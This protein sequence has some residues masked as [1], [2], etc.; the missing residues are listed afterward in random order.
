M[1]PSFGRCPSRLGGSNRGPRELMEEAA[2]PRRPRTRLLPHKAQ[3]R[4]EQGSK[5]SSSFFVLSPPF[6]QPPPAPTATPI[7]RFSRI[8]ARRMAGWLGLVDAQPNR[9]L[10]ALACF[11]LL[12]DDDEEEEDTHTHAFTPSF[13][14]FF[15]K[16]HSTK[17]RPMSK[18]EQDPVV[19][20]PEEDES[21]ESGSDSGSDVRSCLWCKRR[22]T[23]EGDRRETGF[24]CL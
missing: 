5:F 7:D 13:F 15:Y 18:K 2:K 23:G 4:G 12:A 10:R 19:E 3:E 21:S 14:F 1:L 9:R 20:K 8:V 17:T 22:G 16:T 6:M 11:W 24:E